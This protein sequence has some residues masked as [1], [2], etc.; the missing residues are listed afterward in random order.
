MAMVVYGRAIRVF[1]SPSQ[2]Q[3][4]QQQQNAYEKAGV[5]M[6]QNILSY[7]RD[8]TPLGRPTLAGAPPFAPLNVRSANSYRTA[9]SS[10]VRCV[11]CDELLTV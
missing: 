8:P 5:D 2:H 3:Q 7:V 11:T 1:G 4:Q 6:F 9:R 10:D